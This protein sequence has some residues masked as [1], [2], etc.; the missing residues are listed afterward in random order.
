MW[1]ATCICCTIYM[2]LVIQCIDYISISEK[3]IYR[4]EIVLHESFAWM[5]HNF[6]ITKSIC[7]RPSYYTAQ[8]KI[9]IKTLA[10]DIRLIWCPNNVFW[11]IEILAFWDRWSW[12]RRG[13]RNLPPNLLQTVAYGG[14][15]LMVWGG[16]SLNNKTDLIFIR[17]NL[18][19][20]R[21]VEEVV[22]NLCTRN[23]SIF[24]VNARWSYGT[25]FKGHH[26]L[27][28]SM[29]V[30]CFLCLKCALFICVQ[31]ASETNVQKEKIQQPKYVILILFWA[32]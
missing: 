11:W 1:I 27:H 15:S 7:T 26:M 13:E 8:N 25:Y 2:T 32:V 19:A 22:Q 28:W 16:I 18:T 29:F 3:F 31:G 5:E 14:G 21:Y 30:S 6:T 23:W 17:G 9:S 10:W 24:H 20:E 12:R 4:N